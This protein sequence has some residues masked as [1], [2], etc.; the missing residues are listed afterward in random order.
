MEITHTTIIRRTY[1]WPALFCADAVRC[2]SKG[3][4]PALFLASQPVWQTPESYCSP[5]YSRERER[6]GRRKR[7]AGGERDGEEGLQRAETLTSVWEQCQSFP[8]RQRG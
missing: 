1:T 5:H 4:K 7:K 6:K 2:G 3:L 8:F